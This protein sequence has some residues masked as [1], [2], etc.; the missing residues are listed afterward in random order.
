MN[1][2]IIKIEQFKQDISSLINHYDLPI[3]HIYFLVKDLY[4]DIE[5]TYYEYYNQVLLEEQNKKQEEKEEN[6]QDSSNE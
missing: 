5:K 1:D 6:G 4:K 2:N 3:E